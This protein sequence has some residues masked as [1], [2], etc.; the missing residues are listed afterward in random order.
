[1][2]QREHYVMT[3]GGIQLCHDSETQ[4]NKAVK[5]AGREGPGRNRVSID[6][7]RLEG[8]GL[9]DDFR[10]SLTS[11]TK[12]GKDGATAFKI[13]TEKVELALVAARVVLRR[14]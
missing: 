3:I 2:F 7:A 13:L 8:T 10:G 14:N 12:R 5:I 9:L 4:E 11:R 1:V 6:C